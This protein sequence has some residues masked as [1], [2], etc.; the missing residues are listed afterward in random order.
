M[1][2]NLIRN[3]ELVRGSNMP[4]CAGNVLETSSFTVRNCDELFYIA[5]CAVG[6]GTQRSHFAFVDE[7][8]ALQ[9]SQLIPAKHTT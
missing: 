4:A 3:G 1:R 5:Q 9:L 2:F 6:L 8:H 7:Y